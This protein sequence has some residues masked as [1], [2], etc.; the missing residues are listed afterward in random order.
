MPESLIKQNVLNLSA[1]KVNDFQCKAKLDANESP[2]GFDI[3]PEALN[4]VKTNKYPDPEARELRAILSKMW[5]VSPENILHG[6]GSD[7]LIYYCI[8][9]TGG[10][11][12]YPT[13]TFVMYGIIAESLSEATLPI[14]LNEDFEL[15]TDAIIRA[16]HEK[17]PRI[18]FISSPNNPTGNAFA[19]ENIHRIIKESKGL[20][21][22]DE[23]YQPFSEKPSFVPFIGDY[24]NLVVMKTLSKIGFAAL[25]LGFVIGR[26]DI[27]SEINKLRLP[28]NVNSLSQTIA[29][30][31][32]TK[33]QNELSKNI[34]TIISERIRLMERLNEFNAFRVYPS[35]SNFFLIKPLHM[36]GVDLYGKLLEMGVAVKS[37]G[38]VVQTLNDCLRVT[39]G[40]QE[41]NTFFLNCIE[42][43]LNTERTT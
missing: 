17:N 34:Q 8:M 40:T 14:A 3:S 13:P 41:E 35:D 15:D 4:L 18:L 5:C 27:I 39:V 21:V 10:P 26:E 19:V 25:R 43:I 22:V 42:N 24:D 38:A 32:L 36:K 30:D 6:N 1:Y 12:L 11:V 31:L 28:Y 20:V 29:I 37:F 7:E 23:A 9:A 33:K 16:I 2:F